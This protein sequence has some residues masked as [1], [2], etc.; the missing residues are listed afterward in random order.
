MKE[1]KQKLSLYSPTTYQTKVP[2]KFDQS[3]MDWA[4]NMKISIEDDDA[5]V[6]TTTLTSTIDWAALIGILRRLYS[7]GLPLIMVKWVDLDGL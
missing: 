4:G 2:G 5:G 3:W 6:S 1:P 7:L